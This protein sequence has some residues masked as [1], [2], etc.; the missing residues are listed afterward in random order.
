MGL[1]KGLRHWCLDDEQTGL[2]I[3]KALAFA[4]IGI[5]SRGS[6]AT[7][8]SAAVSA[9]PSGAQGFTASRRRGQHPPAPPSTLFY[10]GVTRA[11]ASCI[12]SGWRRADAITST[13]SKTRCM[14]PWCVGSTPPDTITRNR[15]HG[16]RPRRRSWLIFSDS[17]GFLQDRRSI[18]TC[19]HP[20]RLLQGSRALAS[21]HRRQASR[22]KGL[23]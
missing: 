9:A 15:E 8:Q 4:R 6:D 20:C 13:F 14:T 3:L 21:I 12:E 16:L 23:R 22:T 11:A 19:L 10:R 5:L 2:Y 18:E 7:V 1:S 17:K